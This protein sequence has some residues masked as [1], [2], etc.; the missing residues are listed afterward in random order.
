MPPVNILRECWMLYFH[1]AF[2]LSLIILGFTT[3]LSRV[4]VRIKPLHPYLG[5]AWF[6]GILIQASTSL[7]CRKD[8]FK[9][10]IMM[11]MIIL[12]LNM[13]VGHICIR[14]YQ[15]NVQ[16]VLQSSSAK[17][18][19]IQL[20]YFKYIHGG[21]MAI[22]YVMLFGAG[23]MFTRRSKDLANCVS[24]YSPDDSVFAGAVF[25]KKDDGTTLWIGGS[26]FT[27]PE[28]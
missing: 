15:R 14:I 18:C 6:Y 13:I 4:I 1:F 3:L 25:Y 9:W 16:L 27:A 21:C 22:A 26:N 12:I 11:F 2:G 28:L 23:V 17:F 10:F 8:G 5:Q 19:G 7:W 20:H 24:I